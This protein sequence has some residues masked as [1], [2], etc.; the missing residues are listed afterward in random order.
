MSEYHREE[1]GERKKLDPLWQLRLYHEQMMDR[2]RETYTDTPAGYHD[3]EARIL[4]IARIEKSMDECRRM[5]D[6]EVTTRRLPDQPFAG[7]RIEL[8]MIREHLNAGKHAILISG[9]GGIGKSALMGAFAREA[10]A[11]GTYDK[12]LFLPAA[13]GI[14]KAILD[15][16]ILTING[17]MWSARRYRSHQEYLR[18]KLA[19]LHRAAAEKR[20]LILVDD[21]RD[22][23]V[24]ELSALLALPADF[25][26]TSRLAVSAFRELPESLQPQQIA[27]QE[28]SWEELAEM[29]ALL[30]P[31]LSL[32][33]KQQ[34]HELFCS[35]HGHTLALKLW[36]SSD[37]RM[38]AADMLYENYFLDK[39]LGRDA[40]RLLMAMAAMPQEGVDLEWIGKMAGA[41]RETSGQLAERSL[42]QLDTDEEGRTWISIHPLI[43]ENVKQVLKPDLRKC[44][45]LLENT[46]EDVANAWNTPRNEMLVRLPA[47]QSLLKTFK[48]RPA[49]LASAL[50]KLFTFLW[51][52]EDYE[53]AK[54]GYTELYKSV[55]GQFG[56]HSQQAGWMALR[57][58]AAY[59]NSMCFDEAEQWY[60][61]GLKNLRSCKA[62]DPDYYWQRME[63][64]GK[65][66]R[67]PLYRGEMQ[68]V[69]ALLDEADEV[70]RLAP[71][72]ARSDRLLLVKAYH[73]RRKASFLLKSGKMEEAEA[74]REKMHEEMALYFSRC[75]AD[76]PRQLDLRETDIEFELA[77]GH[78]K[79]AV[80][81]LEENMIGYTLYRGPLHE[82]TL[83][84][85]Q[86]LA[87]VLAE[88]GEDEGNRARNL[89]L[90]TAAG[91]RLHYPLE[92]G[93]LQDVEER[94]RKL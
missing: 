51:V 34:Y 72:E 1:S 84:C 90:Q 81:L 64:C 70:F 6:T 3:E 57:A 46:A 49:W 88:L 48:A 7:R 60:V 59:H 93:W 36:L 73:T 37:D 44:R 14:S 42:I 4:A 15:D 10:E 25:L 61:R 24:K 89:Y 79:T 9:I 54:Q 82:D 94:I 17:L 85:M 71:E 43:S 76:G 52:M 56:E 33:E 69:A 40:R 67:G 75:G 65:C 31:D 77:S 19:A 58:G 11:A 27:L 32:Q 83:H 47:I 21:I 16:T 78:L 29:A 38:P 87:D 50:D 62:A 45:H 22:V 20:L 53:G 26:I 35:L 80:P 30:R 55:A 91:I 41:E 13:D 28:M 5:E 63:A 66:T 74:C 86:L 23:K 2:L 18:E 68:Q 12:V 8:G 39:R 92:T